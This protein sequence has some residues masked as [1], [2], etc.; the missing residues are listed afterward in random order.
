MEQLGRV[1]AAAFVG[2]VLV[3]QGQTTSDIVAM[4]S[5]TV[6]EMSVAVAPFAALMAGM[7]VISMGILQL[8]K[9]LVPLRRWFQEAC[10]RQWLKK[11]ADSASE[12]CLK[13]NGKVDSR[14]AEVQLIQYTTGGDSAAFY[15]LPAEQLCGQMNPASQLVLQYPS[16]ETKR[17][18][19]L[20]Y[21]F[22][23]NANADDVQKLLHPPETTMVQGSNPSAEQVRQTNEFVDARNRVS[24]HIQRN[25]DGLQI[26]MTHRWRFWLQWAT[27]LMSFGSALMVSIMMRSPGQTVDLPAVLFTALGA[28]IVAPVARDLAAAIQ[29]FRKS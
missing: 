16:G 23:C 24:N 27:L 5:K 10:V 15:D 11:S 21:C 18:Q 1:C 9:M 7:G 22:A 19:H 12:A 25:I 28:S 13:A 4:I 17:E 29:A 20:F 3:N 2:F 14:L 8:V 6:V 26:A